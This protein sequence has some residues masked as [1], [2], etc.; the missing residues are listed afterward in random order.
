MF[1]VVS[2]VLLL[3][4][5]VFVVLKTLGIDIKITR[6]L[7]EYKNKDK[8]ISFENKVVVITG[9]SSGIGKELALFYAKK[10]ARLGLAARRKDA[11][12]ELKKECLRLG[13]PTVVCCECDVAK[14][15]DCK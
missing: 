14:E 6:K 5:F 12:E 7:W 8:I 13:S 9:A 4:F 11:I 10:K 15:L 2:Y 3:G 1:F